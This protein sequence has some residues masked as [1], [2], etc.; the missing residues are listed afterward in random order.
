MTTH[1][2]NTF[3]P[4]P[5][6]DRSVHQR[7][8]SLNITGSGSEASTSLAVGQKPQ[9]RWQRVRSLNIT[10]SESEASTSL[11]AG[12]KPQHRWQRVRSL[13]IAG[14]CGSVK[15]QTPESSHYVHTHPGTWS[16]Y[17]QGKGTPSVTS[18]PEMIMIDTH[19]SRSL[20]QTAIP[21]PDP[22]SKC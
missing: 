21:H 8:R 3:S 17:T 10:G 15:M 19:Y 12:Q 6:T 1:V 22:L 11:A 9:H 7:V 4:A 18:I 13:N 2:A 16:C 5:F 20:G 14:S